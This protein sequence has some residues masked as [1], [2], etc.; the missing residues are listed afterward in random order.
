MLE[1]KFI[2]QPDHKQTQQNYVKQ[3]PVTLLSIVVTVEDNKLIISKTPRRWCE[4]I[5][6]K[7]R[8]QT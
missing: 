4:E 6:K 5:P 2:F 1:Q 7:T 3:I 8:Y